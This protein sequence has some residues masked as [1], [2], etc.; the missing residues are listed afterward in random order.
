M[1]PSTTTTPTTPVTLTKV[2]DQTDEYLYYTYSVPLTVNAQT[3]EPD[4]ENWAI[5]FTDNGVQKHF[6]S[7][8]RFDA[9]TNEEL[10][11]VIGYLY[12]NYRVMMTATIHNT[13]SI[14]YTSEDW[15]IYTNAKVNA[16]YVKATN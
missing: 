14:S 7:S 6:T 12:A 1:P 13:S 10:E 8:I 15:I 2:T 9:K 3:G 4:S 5:R 11:D 16:L